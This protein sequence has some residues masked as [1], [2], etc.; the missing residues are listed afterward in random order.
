MSQNKFTGMNRRSFVAAGSLAGASLLMPRLSFA[1]SGNVVAGI[2]LDAYYASYVVADELG[3]WKQEGLDFSF[4]QFD[5]GSLG[6]DAIATG[7]ADIAS[8]TMFSQMQRVDKGVELYAVAAIA[9][10]G[11]LFSIVAQEDITKPEDLIGKTIAFPRGTIAHYLFT[12]YASK[13][14][15]PL[16]QIEQK[17]VPAP[18]SIAAITRGD[19]NAFLLWEPWPTRALSLAPGTHKLATLDVDNINVVNWLCVGPSLINDVPRL[20]ATLRAL[21]AASQHIEANR[22][23]AADIV[24]KRLRLPREDAAFQVNNINYS[25][26]FSKDRVM[27]DYTTLSEFAIQVGRIQKA[28]PVE[29]MIRPE[30]M[31]SVNPSLAKGW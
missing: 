26:D 6:Y 23:E 7:N 4:K 14:G 31:Q 20:S 24:A 19:I 21:Q 9:A 11:K 30:F 13:R 22:E 27:H 29:A 5:D 8:A 28:P 12:Q 17:S 2:G 10:S 15:L 25:M 3:F 16:D 18:E 1:G